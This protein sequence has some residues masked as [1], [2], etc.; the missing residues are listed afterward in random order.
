[1]SNHP[2]FAQDPEL[3]YLNHAA[4][5]PW[6]RRTSEAVT[7]FAHENHTRGAERYPAWIAVEKRLRARCQALVNAADSD[8]IAL[9]KNTSEGLSIIAHGLDWEPGDSVVTAAE[10]FPSNLIPW[11]SLAPRGVTT[12]LVKWQPGEAPEAALER[13]VDGSTRLLS[14]SAVQYASGLRMDLER[15]GTF[16][17][18]RGILFCVDAIQG[19]GMLPFDVQAMHA[20]FAVADGHKWLLGPEGLALFYCRA[21]HLERLQLHQFGWHMVEHMGDYERDDWTPASSARRFECGS[22]NMLGIH[23]LDASLSLIEELGIEQVAAAIREH[24][25]CLVDGLRGRA[26][27]TRLSPLEPSRRAGIVVFRPHDADLEKVHR[28]LLDRRVICAR[29]AGGI[30]LSPH[31]YHGTATLERALAAIDAVL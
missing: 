22:P 26:D 8:E 7:R 16:C 12:R 17:R 6:P 2:E 5:A 21:E 1:M 19:L 25:D 18:R 9:L 10:E 28:G 23:A 31:F 11:Q 30:R 15:L 29:R 3:A 20:D 24:A 13:A 14:I 27:C 4:V